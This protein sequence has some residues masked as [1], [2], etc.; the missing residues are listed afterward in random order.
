MIPPQSEIEIPLLEVLIE[1][2]GEA[3]PR[4]I[5]SRVTAKIP[6]ITDEDLG[7]RLKAGEKKWTNRIQWTRQA[8]I[9]SGD[10]ASPQRGVWAITEPGAA[11]SKRQRSR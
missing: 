2:V 10:M 1:M 3:R 5:Y 7:V 6:A 11:A 8:L 9:T 4:D